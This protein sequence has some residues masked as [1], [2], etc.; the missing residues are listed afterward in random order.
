MKKPACLLLC[1]FM[2]LSVLAAVPAAA[3]SPEGDSAEIPYYTHNYVVSDS[4][5]AQPVNAV[6]SVERVL[7]RE[8]WEL[9]RSASLT[10]YAPIKTVIF[11]FWTARARALL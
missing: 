3:V 7:I 1:I 9:R 5:S 8:S 2:A 6:Y 10:M 11:I 4:C